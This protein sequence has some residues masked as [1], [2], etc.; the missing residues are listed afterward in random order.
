MPRARLR[1][2][3]SVASPSRLDLFELVR[4][5]SSFLSE[6]FREPGPNG[7]RDPLLL[8]AVE[9]VARATGG[10]HPFRVALTNEADRACGAIL[11]RAVAPDAVP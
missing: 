8:R 1:R 4:A 2:S 5:S 3:S 10:P 11:P 7:Q 6:L 9:E